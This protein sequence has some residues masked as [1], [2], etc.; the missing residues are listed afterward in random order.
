MKKYESIYIL[1]ESRFPDGGTDFIEN[2]RTWVNDSGGEILEAENLG[3]RQLAHPIRKK[4]VG[5]YWDVVMNFPT[6]KIKELKEKFRLNSSVL[7]LETFIYD[8]PEEVVEDKQ[9]IEVETQL[10][11]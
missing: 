2:L 1:D 7:R 9:D 10:V 3:E 5:I 4:N 6:E 11:E 8:R